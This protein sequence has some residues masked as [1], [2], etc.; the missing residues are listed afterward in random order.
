MHTSA[1]GA[2]RPEVSG[3]EQTRPHPAPEPSEPLAG[4]RPSSPSGPPDLGQS[5][6]HCPPRLGL[7][8]LDRDAPQSF[9]NPSTWAVPQ[10]RLNHGKESREK[11]ASMLMGLL[12]MGGGEAR[13]QPGSC[14]P[15]PLRAR[16]T[17][18]VPS[19][20][21]SFSTPKGRSRR[22]GGHTLSVPTS[23]G[24]GKAAAA[25][26]RM[27]PPIL[28]CSLFPAGVSRP[29]APSCCRPEGSL[30]SAPPHVASFRGLGAAGPPHHT[31]EGH[32]RPGSG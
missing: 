3:P 10:P 30:G 9:H 19:Q 5:W 23:K 11:L 12:P 32:Q 29:Q 26:A 21:L 28:P 18:P 6:G 15:T 24:P 16:G 13:V 31:G 17:L 1:S 27:P 2:A 22:A 4:K 8:S 25:T 14:T 7:S 20:G